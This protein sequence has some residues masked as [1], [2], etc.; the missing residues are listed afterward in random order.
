MGLHGLPIFSGIGAVA[1][2]F[3]CNLMN[4]GG[5]G[6]L[7]NIIVG[8]TGAAVGGFVLRLPGISTGGLIGSILT[9]TD[10]AALLLFSIGPLKL[11]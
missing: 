6:L 7:E 8:I 9:A 5:S 1:G 3:P 4:G 2:C 11:T 10:G